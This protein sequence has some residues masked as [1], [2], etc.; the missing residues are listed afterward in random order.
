[1]HR[2]KSYE[3]VEVG[4]I[5]PPSEAKSLLVRI[6]R[7]CPWNRCKFCGLY[8]DQKFSIRPTEHVIQDLD[9]VKECID[10]FH[11]AVKLENSSKKDKM[12][13]DLIASLSQKG[14]PSNV[15]GLFQIASSWFRNGMESIFLQDANSMVIKPDDMVAILQHIKKLFPKV[16]RITTYARSQTIA[17]ISDEDLQ[18]ISNAGLNRIH[19]GM[20]SASDT[21]LDLIN[22]GVKKEAHIIAGQK[23]KKTS[24]ELSEYFM[25]GLGGNEYSTENAIET[26]TAMNAINPDFIRIRTLALPDR[27]DL[28]DDYQNGVFTRTNDV[29]IVE[30]LCLFIQNLDGITSTVKSD[31]ILNL[32]AE[33]EGK[34]PD[35]KPKMIN[36]MNDFLNLEKKEQMIFQ[37]GRRTAVMNW[38]HDLNNP[39]KRSIVEQII[40]EE[41]ITTDNLD[42]V[43]DE[44]MKRF[45]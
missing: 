3:G 40:S 17:K 12:I 39:N 4:P 7:N 37:V 14:N 32:I 10:V 15:N 34:L 35:D 23:I 31:H 28:A 36:A 20:E 11:E 9:Q 29:K 45:I 26:A 13:D 30:E 8:K 6:T 21:V 1:L 33:V 38:M 2:D 27:T 18:R 41:G 44:K 42:G 43:I 22:K 5:R 25:P 19:I 16:E 24:I